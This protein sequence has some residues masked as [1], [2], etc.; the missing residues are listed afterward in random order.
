MD[1]VINIWSSG[2]SVH[3]AIV[4]VCKFIDV[5]GIVYLVNNHPFL[6]SFQSN[7]M[8]LMIIDM[9][10]N[11]TVLNEVDEG[12]AEKHGNKRRK[13]EES[14]SLRVSQLLILMHFFTLKKIFF[15]LSIIMSTILDQVI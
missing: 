1:C 4:L 11:S 14:A 2:S 12:V 3:L 8:L 13:V 10:Y 6:H 7:I 5:C 15:N 9:K